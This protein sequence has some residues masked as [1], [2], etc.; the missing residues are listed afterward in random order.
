MSRRKCSPI[1]K[2]KLSQEELE[3]LLKERPILSP[4]EALREQIS[5]FNVDRF[6][7]ETRDEAIANATISRGKG[8]YM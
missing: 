5:E 7:K 1:T 3:A 2:R 4:E 6:E 8:P